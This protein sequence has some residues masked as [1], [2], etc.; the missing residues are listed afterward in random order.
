MLNLLH[1][2]DL[3]LEACFAST[4]LPPSVGAERRQ[5]LRDALTRIAALARERQV[6]ALTIGG[7]LYEQAYAAPD[8]GE[9]LRRQFA[10]LAPIQ[11]FIAPGDSDPY[12]GD[13]LY[14]LAPWPHNVSIFTGRELTPVELAPGVHLWGAACPPEP[15]YDTP[16]RV[17]VDRM[18]TNLLL[19]H[20][21]MAGQGG[22][23][24]RRVYRF[25]QAALGGAGF[26]LALLGHHH[27]GQVLREGGVQ[28]VYPGSPE[29]LAPIEAESDHQVVLVTVDDGACRLERIPIDRWRYKVLRVDLSG[30]STLEDA[31]ALV[32]ISLR[33]APGGG[34]D[35]HTICRVNLVGTRQFESPLTGIGSRVNSPAHVQYESG[36]RST[37]YDLEQLAYE[38][39]PR[40]L[41]VRRLQD[42]MAAAVDDTERSAAMNALTFALKALDGKR[43]RPNE[44]D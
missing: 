27:N 34:V 38:P 5:G 41:L 43:V 37:A 21:A 33:N 30:C 25:G 12:T 39:T 11:V 7:D 20:A 15:G 29:P 2:A 18:G 28:C 26:D 3:H 44:N 36:L 40:G 9:F 4:H 17:R 16:T 24:A 10:D 42:R 1:C 6:D 19:L 14:A 8:L 13:S 23:D 35:E 31:G 22:S 32:S